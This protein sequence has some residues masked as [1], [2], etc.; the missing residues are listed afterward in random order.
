MAPVTRVSIHPGR[1]MAEGLG[2]MN[3]KSEMSDLMLSSSMDWTV[4]LWYPKNADKH[5]AI[6][7]FESS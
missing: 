6:H 5:D 4:K 1:S 7:T 2:N 3:A